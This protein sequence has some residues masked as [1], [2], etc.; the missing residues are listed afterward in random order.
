MKLDNVFK[1]T[2]LSSARKSYIAL[3]HRGPEVPEGLLRKCNKC[4]GAIIAED[5]KKGYYICPKCGGYFRVHAYRRI[6][7]VGDEGTFEEWDK[8]LCT[9]NPLHYKGYEEKIAHLQEKTGL[10]E[11]VV[12]GKVKI[13]G[14]DTV[15]GVC[16][17]RFMMSSMGEVVGEKITRAVERATREK[18]PVILFTCSGGARMQEGIVSLMQM[19]KTSAALKRHSDAGLLYVTVLTD[20]TTGGVTASFAMLGDIILAEPGALIGFAGPR[21]IEQTIGQK[22][23]KG[24]QRAEFLVEHGFVDAIVERPKLRETLGEI[25]RM[26]SRDS[27]LERTLEGTASEAAEAGEKELPEGAG[28]GQA[29]ASDVRD[30]LKLHNQVAEA[31]D[32]VQ[33]SRMKD[34]PVGSDYIHALFTDFMEFHGDR[35]YRD[36]RA[37]IGG[38]AYFHGMPVTVIAQEK[39][40]NT[41]ENIEHNFGMPSPDGYRK[42]LRLMKQAEKF[43]RPV[44]CFVDTPGAFCGLEAEERGQ[45]EAIARNLFEM[46]GLT[47]PVLSI[48]I[49]EGG[50]GGALAMAV[51]DEVWMLENSIYSILSPEGFASIL[52]KDSSKAKEAAEVMKLTAGDLYELGM[53][54]HVF[55]EPSH[56][57][58]QNLK[59][60]TREMDEKIREFIGQY[61]ALTAEEITERR[62]QRFRQM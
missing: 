58:V 12:T 13:Q 42:A 24:F 34:R 33:I 20:P 5:V 44:I 53:V 56:Y 27:V 26:H 38:I 35:Y 37:I 22:L 43:G 28:N 29:G 30:G 3:N 54:E 9:R 61:G 6:E 51:A 48:V 52:W 62:Y 41:K 46:S 45:G 11:A 31:W 8:G 49:G 57:T 17:G 23:P 25:L 1:K 39:G 21:V 18:M 19:A 15:I 32:R 16:D 50:S 47:V 36:D 55:L 4:G 60:V 40:T 2:R 14:Q 59:E 7:M 10:E